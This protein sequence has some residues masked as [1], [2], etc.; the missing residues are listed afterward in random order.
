MSIKKVPAKKT[1]EKLKCQATKQLLKSKIIPENVV[2]FIKLE[3]KIK[4]MSSHIAH[5]SN[6]FEERMPMYTIT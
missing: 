1:L 2:Q 5:I 3:Q 6:I 4:N